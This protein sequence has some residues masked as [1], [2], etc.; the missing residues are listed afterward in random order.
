MCIRDSRYPA[1]AEELKG[2]SVYFVREREIVFRMPFLGMRTEDP[3]FSC[4]DM[5]PR[6]ILVEPRPV[7]F[8]RGWRYLRPEDA[9]PDIQQNSENRQQNM[10]DSIRSGLK[11]AGLL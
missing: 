8:L 6:I 2:G 4:I 7:R 3:E 10:P 11:E 5:E 9:P 1:R